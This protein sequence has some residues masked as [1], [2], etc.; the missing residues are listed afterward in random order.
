MRDKQSEDSNN[1]GAGW[2]PSS[3]V[4]ATAK[5]LSRLQAL[6]AARSGTPSRA[7]P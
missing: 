5:E 3:F 2:F 7:T 1:V 6:L 4:E